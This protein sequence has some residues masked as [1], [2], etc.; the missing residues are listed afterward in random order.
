M[1]VKFKFILLWLIFP[2]SWVP[3]FEGKNC[4]ENCT[5][6]C[7]ENYIEISYTRKLGENELLTHFIKSKLHLSTG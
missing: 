7:I 6:N 5:D 3:D 4:I 2:C 1:T